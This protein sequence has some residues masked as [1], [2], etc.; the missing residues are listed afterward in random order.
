[1]V[2]QLRGLQYTLVYL[3]RQKVIAMEYIASF[4]LFLQVTIIPLWLV[5]FYMRITLGASG[6]ASGSSIPVDWE[7]VVLAFH[8]GELVFPENLWIGSN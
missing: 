3:S 1:M 4:Q 5:V 6:S 8:H 2:L 7:P